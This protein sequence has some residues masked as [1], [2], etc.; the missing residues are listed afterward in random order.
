MKNAITTLIGHIL[1]FLIAFS[2]IFIVYYLYRPLN[3]EIRIEVN[4]RN[5]IKEFNKLCDTLMIFSSLSENSSTI[6]KMEISSSNLICISNFISLITDNY[7]QSAEKEYYSSIRIGNNTLN[8]EVLSEDYVNISGNVY[9]SNSFIQVSNFLMYIY[10]FN[11]EINKIRA[12]VFSKKDNTYIGCF[13]NRVSHVCP[14]KLK[15]CTVYCKGNCKLIFLKE[16]EGINIKQV[17]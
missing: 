8:F 14:V 13:R 11:P 5:S 9:P 7:C 17:H 2:A 15:N 12:I 1:I 10:D 16:K 3:K 4:V 6:E